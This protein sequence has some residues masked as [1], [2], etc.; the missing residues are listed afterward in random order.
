MILKSKKVKFFLITRE[1]KEFA[2]TTKM[3]IKT[4]VSQ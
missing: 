1:Y 2:I 4:N 3:L